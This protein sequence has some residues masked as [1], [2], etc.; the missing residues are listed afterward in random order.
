MV[1]AERNQFCHPAQ[2]YAATF[3]DHQG[4]C[5]VSSTPRLRFVQD[6]VRFELME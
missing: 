6:D 1:T 3:G 2:S 4:V 5:K